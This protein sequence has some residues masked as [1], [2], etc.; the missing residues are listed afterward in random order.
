M[1]RHAAPSAHLCC[2]VRCSKWTP[3]CSHPEV[4]SQAERTN[5]IKSNQPPPKLVVLA[6]DLR[7]S[8]RMLSCFWLT[9]LRFSSISE[10][11]VWKKPKGAVCTGVYD[12]MC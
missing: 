10:Q 5:W 1:N 12:T 11:G 4:V 7:P 2:C 3:F 9:W 6:S 8:G